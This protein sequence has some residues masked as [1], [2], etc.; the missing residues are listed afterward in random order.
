MSSLAGSSPSGML[1]LLLSL[2]PSSA[3]VLLI[4]AL[5]LVLVVLLGEMVVVGALHELRD[6][7][8]LAELFALLLRLVIIAFFEELV[9][10]VHC[11]APWLQSEDL[12]AS[13]YQSQRGA[14]PHQIVAK[15]W[16]MPAVAPYPI[17]FFRSR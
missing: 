1:A 15:P 12:L 10:H 4:S 9:T 7:R 14:F 3:R 5:F 8:M 16:T 17:P 11:V 6:E 13:A 2:T